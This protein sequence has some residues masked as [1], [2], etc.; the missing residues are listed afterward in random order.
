MSLILAIG[1]NLADKLQN[2]ENV[3]SI[4]KSHYDF[5]SESDVFESVA[6]DYTDQPDFYNQVLEFKIPLDKT[7]Q[8]VM[9]HLLEIEIKL[10]RTRNIDKGPRTVDI[11]M[12]FWD[13]ALI[14]EENLTVP[15]PRWIE[16]SFVVRPLQQ[17]PFFKKIEKCFKIPH[18]FN[19]EAKPIQRT[20]K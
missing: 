3:S 13:Q 2:L 14:E 19:I 16:R 12:I 18:K 9:S 7:P 11:D 20:D 17:L 4:L 1:S 10:G 8:Q 15:H 6:V 5:I